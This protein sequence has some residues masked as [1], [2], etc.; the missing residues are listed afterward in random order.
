[1][2]DV[3]YQYE[4]NPTTWVYFSSLLTIAIFFKFSRL[5]SIRN[6][7]LLG[8]IALAPGLLLVSLGQNA[9]EQANLAAQAAAQVGE[10]GLAAENV[11]QL[12][13]GAAGLAQ[14]TAAVPPVVS[15]LE[16]MGYGWLFIVGLFFLIRLI[17]DPLMARRPLLEPNLTAGGLSFLGLCLF[18]FLMA[19]VVTA[20]LPDVATDPAVA[21]AEAVGDTDVAPTFDPRLG[22]PQEPTATPIAELGPAGGDIS[23]LPAASLA[24]TVPTERMPAETSVAATSGRE[25]ATA[26][27]AA[28]PDSHAPGFTVLDLFPRFPSK[29][30]NPNPML[31]RNLYQGRAVFAVTGRVLT[32]VA[33]FMIL[34]GLIYLGARYFNNYWT[35][36]GM[37]TLYLML[38]YTAYLAG[39]IRHVAPGALLVWMMAAYRRPL[40]V[41]SLLAMAVGAVYYP[42]FLIPLFV[43]FYWQRGVLRFA[44]GLIGTFSVLLLLAAL[45]APPGF[46]SIL[47]HFPQMFSLSTENLQGFWASHSPYLRIPLVALFLALCFGMA[48]WPAQ[49][50]LGTLMS[51]SAAVMLGTQFWYPQGGLLFMNWYLPLLLL[52]VFRPNLEN[53]MAVATFGERWARGRRLPSQAA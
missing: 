4:L 53:R 28:E 24:E 51:C 50:N 33:H 9:T 1:M 30:F 40:I 47:Q 34:A 2:Q 20:R 7:D 41:G 21:A 29:A 31:D 8:L 38:P 39:D 18:V 42:M 45:L 11:S 16:A 44:I 13:P 10:N 32:I 52:T 3:L 48:I 27:G 6:V 37:A 46:G 22:E 23:T 15:E 19:N 49:K 36:I 25:A 17:A 43:G 14:A 12:A 5:W 26:R 35:G